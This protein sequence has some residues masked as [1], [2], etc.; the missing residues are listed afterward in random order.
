MT[1]IENKT[2]DAE[3]A[4]YGSDGVLVRGCA[5]DGPPTARAPSRRAGT[6]RL[7]TA[8]STCATHS[9]TRAISESELTDKCPRRAL[10]QRRR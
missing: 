6:W 5:F 7:K 10:V 4:L 9:G 2:M 1:I 3:R 8:S